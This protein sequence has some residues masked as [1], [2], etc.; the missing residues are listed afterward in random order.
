MDQTTTGCLFCRIVRGELGTAFLA[1]NEGAVAFRDVSPRAPT[2]VLVVPKRHLD[3][4]NGLE[5]EDRDVAADLLL[6]ARQIARQEGIETSGYRLI[7]N[8]GSDA[9]QTVGHLHL[10]VLGGARLSE[11]FG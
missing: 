4:L 9:G 10:H 5:D 6:L 3:D 1:E 11:P 2:H 8:N 7:V